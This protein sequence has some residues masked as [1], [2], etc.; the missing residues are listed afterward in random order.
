MH[1]H[2]ISQQS[3]WHGNCQATYTQLLFLASERRRLKTELCVTFENIRT[4][5]SDYLTFMTKS[6]SHITRL[7]LIINIIKMYFQLL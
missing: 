1:V 5:Q 2:T 3:D 6:Y 7:I 4:N